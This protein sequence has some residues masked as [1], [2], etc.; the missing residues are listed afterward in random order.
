M[1]ENKYQGLAGWLDTRLEEWRN[2]RDSNYLDNWDEYYRL[3]RGIWKASD[4]TRQAEKSRLIS[5]AL[6]Q[7]VESS[8]AEIEEAT[9]GRGKWF[10]IKD[11]MLDQNPSDAEYVRNLLQEDLEY[12]GC[13]DALCE[14]FLKWCCIWY[15]YW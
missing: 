9:F 4:K 8:V 6:Q 11:D 2:H 5:P 15:W 10:D 14:V 1:D 12:T 13:K 7:A 3:W